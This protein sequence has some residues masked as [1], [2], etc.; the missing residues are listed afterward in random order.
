MWSAHVE[1]T[2]LA[3]KVCRYKS[4]RLNSAVSRVW[5]ASRSAAIEQLRRRVAPAYQKSPTSAAKYAQPPRWVL[6]DAVR[7]ADLGL[8]RVPPL[9][10]LDIGCGPGY[11]L[12][13]GS[14]LGHQCFG[15]D[16]PDQ[17][18]DEVERDVYATLTEALHCSQQVS[19][20][21][22]ERFQPLPFRDRPFDC[23][24]AFWICFNRHR[25]PD[26]WGT[27]EW[28]YFVEDALACLRPGGRIVLE[29]NENPELYGSLRFYDSATRDYFRSVGTVNQGR[30]I[31]A[32]P[33][34]LAASM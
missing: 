1:T 20:L 30:V 19:P 14:A 7:I 23:I 25:Q 15:V 32:R 6:R 26:E 34:I 27:A 21:L 16:L 10:V 4:L 24:T 8:H 2:K 28:R 9:R 22:I 18:F 13:L 12:A 31:V 17:F 33:A 3:L 11:F 29:L 5:S